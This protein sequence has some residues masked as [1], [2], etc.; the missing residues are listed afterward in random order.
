MSHGTTEGGD[1]GRLDL[2]PM[3]DCVMLLLMFFILTSNFKAEDMRI[4]ALLPTNEGG[5]PTGPVIDPPRTVRI[6]ILPGDGRVARVRIGGGEEVQIDADQ[7][8][9]PGGPVVEQAIATIHAAL[10]SR[11]AAYEQPGARCDQ[12]PVE[13]HCATRLPWSCALVVYDA[14]R[15]YEMDRAPLADLPIEQQR[16]VAF[17]SPVVRNSSADNAYDELQRLEHLR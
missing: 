2:V 13:I 14:V 1:E 11:L 3:I 5:L 4:S 15:A 6:A 16:A 17:A 7:L 9:Q 8:A 12:S 10:A